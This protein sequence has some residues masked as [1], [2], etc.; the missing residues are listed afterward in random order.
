MSNAYLFIKLFQLKH[1]HLKINIK[2]SL[3]RFGLKYLRKIVTIF[4]EFVLGT[5]FKFFKELFLKIDTIH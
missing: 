4:L 5:K 2:S 3:I 1:C